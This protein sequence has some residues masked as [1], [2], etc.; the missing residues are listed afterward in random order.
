M[1]AILIIFFTLIGLLVLHEFGHFILAKKFGVQVEEFGIG[2]PPRIF[3]KKIGQTLYSLNLL[4]FGAFV[5][6]TGEEERVKEPRSFSQKPIWQRALILLGGVVSFWIVAFLI[7][8][9][10]SATWGLP[11]AIPDEFQGNI[12]K[13]R[14]QIVGISPNSP[15]Q[16][17]QLK[18]GDIIEEFKIQNSKFKIEKIKNLQGLI[19]TYKGKEIT[20][21]VR[22]GK[23]I[24]EVSLIP[25][26][27]PPKGEGAIGIALV[28]AANLKY[29][30]YQAPFQGIK[31]T[32][33]QTYQIPVILG[34]V[35]ARSIRGEKVEG[36]RFMGPIGIGNMMR[37]SLEMGL[38][39]FLMLV[40][41]ISIWLALFN[42]FPIPALDGGKLLFLLIEGIRKRPVSQLVEQRITAFFFFALII[43]MIFVTINDIIGLF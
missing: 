1:L 25:R 35:L 5:K 9:V 40:G 14:V 7:F 10:L 41:I 22:R 34:R 24:F 11:T 6:I 21:V 2:Y 19:Q 38:D 36:V 3:G 31:V 27:S 26:V 39:N 29:P 18:P 17:A 13:A 16:R 23:K 33:Q 32:A 28:R 43:L 37:Q 8:S 4:P 15:A 20:L 30:W 12:S 42:L